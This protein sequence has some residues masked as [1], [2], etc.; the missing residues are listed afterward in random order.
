MKIKFLTVLMLMVGTHVFGQQVNKITGRL[1]TT[2]G[3]PVAYAT[4]ILKGSGTVMK[5]DAN[6][7]FSM[8]YNGKADTLF[9]T[10]IGYAP[11]SV[12]VKGYPAQPLYITL[13]EAA[14][15]MEEVIVNTG[16]QQLPKERATGSFTQIDNATF[17]QQVSADV[18]SRLPAVANGLSEGR[19]TSQGGYTAN[20]NIL[21]RGLSTINGPSSP[22]IILDNFPYDG[23]INNINPN[24]VESVTLLKDAASASIWGARA[25][26]GVIVIT[27]KKS[28][29]HQKTKIE[30]N[31]NFKITQKP[32]LYYAKVI[33][34]P[35][36]INVEKFLFNNQYRF[37]DT[38]NSTH[39]PFS[40]AYEILFNQQNGVITAS[41]ATNEL[42]ALSNHD[43]RSDLN[44]YIYKNGVNQQYALN[45]QGGSENI[46]WLLSG[47]FDKDL[48][49]LSAGYN[50]V[51]LRSENTIRLTPDLQLATSVLYTQSKSTSGRP[52]YGNILTVNGPVPGYTFLADANGNPLPVAKDYRQFYLDNIAGSVPE[53]WNY[54][55]LEDYQYAHTRNDLQDA[56]GDISLSYRPGKGFTA[57]VKYQYERQAG[58]DANYYDEQSYYARNLINTFY[59]PGGNV[60]YPVPK[61]GIADFATNTTTAN[62]LRAQL[63]YNHAWGDNE[64]TALAGYE[65]RQTRMQGNSHRVYGYDNDILTT[66]PVDL[67]NIYPSYVTGDEFYVPD[68]SGVDETLNR[69]I[70]YFANAAYTYK[71]KYTLTVSGRRDAS[72]LFGVNTNDKW[73]PLWS[74]GAGWLISSEKFYHAVFLPKLRLRATYGVSGNI[75]PSLTAVTTLNYGATSP[76]T[77]QPYAMVNKYYNPDLRWEKS[78]Q[79][80]I[81]LDFSTAHNRIAG[82][83]DYYIKRGVDLYG[84]APLDYTAGL[85]IRYITKNAADMVAHGMDV[86][87]NSLNIDGRLRWTTH[88]NTSIY[89]DKVTSY[90]LSTTDGSNFINDGIGISGIVGK[91][92]NSVLS[93][94]WAGLDPATGGPRGYLHGKVSEDYDNI[95]GGG[96]PLSDLVYSGPGLPTLCGSMGNT[97]SYKHISLTAVITYKFGYYFRKQSISYSTLFSSLNGTADFA[98]RWQKP[99]DELHTNVPSM[100]YPANSSR[101]Q[102][103]NGS[104]VLIEKGDNVRLQYI[105]ISWDMEKLFKRLPAAAITLYVSVNNIGIIWRANKDHLDPE[106]T[107]GSIPPSK[108][109]AIGLRANF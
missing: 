27:T 71:Q 52:G 62:N 11:V 45:I 7:N 86:E 48:D 47:G 97:I 70:S 84:P 14:G 28:G 3:D 15:L 101:D 9:I 50:R 96:T 34:S 16:Y 41:E 5:A 95:V 91:P 4:I 55:P 82:S 17:N 77:M 90:F 63:T 25:G 73:N 67:V 57:A 40:P 38:L 21:I 51:S 29:F 88:L 18:I 10:H 12:P 8:P 2:A 72:N 81:G 22:L 39:P 24:D 69:F 32:D 102:F 19:K 58:N 33:S 66:V 35:D 64:I 68:N 94:K 46:A 43:M 6:G 30:L 108:N 23:D 92:V 60:M 31:S 89:H 61:G 104:E 53:D 85:G 44:K 78:R 75:D 1:V 98:N 36:L 76:Y 42:A 83:V 107:I 100:V 105:T 20:G 49:V 37:D 74:A 106:Y 56:L 99:G 109:I 87:V 93:Y 80:N 103:Y 79:L 54:Y 26:N 65:N 59:Q 13:K